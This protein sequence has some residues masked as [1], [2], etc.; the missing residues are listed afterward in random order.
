MKFG[1]VRLIAGS[2]AACLLATS[3]G[4]TGPAE[5]ASVGVASPAELVLNGSFEQNT[6]G[7]SLPDNWTGK[8]LVAT[9]GQ[10]C[11]SEAHSGSCAVHLG[12]GKT[13]QLGFTRKIN[14]NPGEAITFSLMSKALSAPDGK[15]SAR[16]TFTYWNNSK[17]VWTTP[18]PNGTT[19]WTSTQISITPSKAYRQISVLIQAAGKSGGDL[20]L[21]DVSL[22]VAPSPSGWTPP[23]TAADWAANPVHGAVVEIGFGGP[24][25][26]EDPSYPSLD[27]FRL[28]RELGVHVVVIEFQYAWTIFPPYQAAEDQFTR[29]TAALDNARDAGLYVVLANRSGPGVNAMY[30]G[31]ADKD[32]ITTLYTDATAQQA[33]RDML[34]DMVN[35]YKNRPEIIAWEPIIEPAPD[36][37]LYHED[38]PPYTQGSAVWNPL[39]NSFIQT[40]RAADPNRPII[41]EPV[42]WGGFDA[43]A[44]FTKFSDNNVI[45][46]LHTYE[47]YSY[48]DQSR[49][50]FRSYPGRFDGEYVNKSV[51]DS[52]L[53][54]VDD[55]QALHNVPIYVGEWGGIRWVPGMNRY[56]ADQ[57]S[58][59][60]TRGWSWTIYA[61]YD[62]EWDQKG[63][64]PALGKNRGKPVYNPLNPVFA[65]VVADWASMP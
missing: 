10:V 18:I 9:D 48:T 2:V 22:S 1:R 21:D 54:P 64:M 23:A 32:V 39:A 27:S 29:V 30:P 16:I 40:I 35:R 47:P 56:I 58:L 62:A 6:G 61:W 17:K 45:Y 20:W 7:S 26:F 38:S 13:K 55:F 24:D 15:F 28:L 5:A 63:Y 65:P 37:F 4:M 3:L 57:L 8:K 46:S 51:L 19:G 12:V 53:A 59:F 50:P 43:F 42:N 11:G 49:A 41:I 60:N 31:I 33:Y 14:G 52:F 36:H 44:T 34:T 25:E